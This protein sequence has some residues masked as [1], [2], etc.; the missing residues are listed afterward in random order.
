[1]NTTAHITDPR[2]MDA[3]SRALNRADGFGYTALSCALM[4]DEVVRRVRFFGVPEDVAI[5]QVVLPKGA[6]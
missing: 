6:M 1:M 4:A 2:Q 3:W 5:E